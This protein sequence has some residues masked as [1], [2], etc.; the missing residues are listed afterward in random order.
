PDEVLQMAASAKRMPSREAAYRNLI[1]NQRVESSAPFIMPA[2]WQA[3]AGASLDLIGRDVFAGLDLSET[4][5]LTAL[6]LVGADVATGLWHCQPTFW[7]PSE[8]L[9]DKAAHDRIP[10][11]LWARQGYLQTTPG[12][13]V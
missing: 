8:G 9:A 13:T 3:C 7:L 11:D 5:D 2:Q 1:L 10:Y 4:Q 12:H 6:V